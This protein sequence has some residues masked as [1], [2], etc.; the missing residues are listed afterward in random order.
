MKNYGIT[1]KLRGSYRVILILLAV[2][3]LLG[4]VALTC[5]TLILNKF[6]SKQFQNVQIA[7]EVDANMNASAKNMLHAC[8]AEEK[9]EIESRLGQ[10]EQKFQVVE[11]ALDSMKKAYGENSEVTA[12][13]QSFKAAETKYQTL[14]QLCLENKNREAFEVYESQIQPLLASAN[15]NIISIRNSANESA[16]K[17]YHNGVALNY[18]FIAIMD[19]ID[20]MGVVIGSRIS[21]STTR[22]LVGGITELKDAALKMS[23]GDFDLS[24]TYESNDELGDLSNSMRKMSSDIKAV[25]E[26]TDYMLGTMAEGDFSVRTKIEERY[27]GLFSGLLSS[28]RQ[29]R[30]SLNDVITQINQS[31]EQVSGGSE[32]VSAGAQALSQGATEQASSIEELAATTNE[33][34]TKVEH[35]ADNAAAANHNTSEVQ[36]QMGRC[37]SQMEDLIQAMDEISQKS[38]EIGKIIKTIED[39]AFQTNILALNAAVEAARA[40]EAGK[41]FAVVADEVRNLASKSAEASKNTAI[42]I[43][44]TVNAVSNGTNI[45]NATAEALLKAAESVKKS[46]AAVGAISREAD[47]EATAIAQI[48]QGIDQISSVVQTNSAT[49]EESAASSEELSGQAQILKNL[50]NRFTL[51][52]KE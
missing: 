51:L 20:I 43:D 44:G 38:G 15:E 4:A 45:T 11:Q 35:M 42:L 30:G 9:S 31:A 2:E 13:S 33:I 48:T 16:K 40:G 18:L 39:I 41:G 52:E 27:V 1:K 36:E 32:Q 46:A 49:A 7:D 19:V 26:D 25:I 8:L 10:V 3:L 23:E 22:S 14:R 24:L 47:A 5:S 50:V 6:Y 17:S 37:Q 21:K 29:M 28:M 34:S 12:L